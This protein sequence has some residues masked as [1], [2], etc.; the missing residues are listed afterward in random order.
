ME[1]LIAIPANNGV[2]SMHFGHCAY[3]A[4]YHV[5]DNKV[6]KTS[7]LNAPPHE[8]GLLPKWLKE[9]GA[10]VIIAGGMGQMAIDLFTK[11]NIEVLVGVS[12]NK[13]IDEVVA[14]YLEGKISGGGNLCDHD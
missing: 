8:P 14:D 1:K 11:Q 5:I 2:L 10:N 3:F 4:L 13:G 12:S 6:V 7:M 9:R